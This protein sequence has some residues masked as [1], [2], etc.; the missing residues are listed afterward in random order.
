MTDTETKLPFGILD[1]KKVALDETVWQ[2]PE[3]DRARIIVQEVDQETGETREIRPFRFI[4]GR[5]RILDDR[6]FMSE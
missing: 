6:T 3:R 1:G 5:G 4:G 2:L